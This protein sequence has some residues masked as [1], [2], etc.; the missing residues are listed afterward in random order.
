M[1][2]KINLS[3]SSREKLYAAARYL[4]SETERDRFVHGF[5]PALASFGESSSLNA[6]EVVG[7]PGAVLRVGLSR[8]VMVQVQEGSVH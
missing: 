8:E 2:T 6:L 3:K 1:A 5:Q 7:R 4:D